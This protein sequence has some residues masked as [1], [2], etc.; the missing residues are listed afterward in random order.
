MIFV[1]QGNVTVTARIME[2]ASLVLMGPSSAAV[3]HSL[4]AAVARR[5]D[6]TD[7]KMENAV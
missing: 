7:A 2:S 4:K 1:L 3:F 5:T 6:A